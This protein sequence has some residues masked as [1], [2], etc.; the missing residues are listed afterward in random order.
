[1][2]KSRSAP[3]AGSLHNPHTEPAAHKLQVARYKFVAN[4][5]RPSYH[6][7]VLHYGVGVPSSC[8]IF[9]K[10]LPTTG[11]IRNRIAMTTL[12]TK[13]KTGI[14]DSRTTATAAAPPESE[15]TKVT[16]SAAVK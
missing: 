8:T 15:G 14:I 4:A 12:E 9:E 7:W 10:T 13:M 3:G 1:M 6:G 5:Y 11:P 16:G 2:G